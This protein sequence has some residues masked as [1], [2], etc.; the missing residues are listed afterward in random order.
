MRYSTPTSI[1]QFFRYLLFFWGIVTIAGCASSDEKDHSEGWSAQQL[2]NEA[3][4]ERI[5]GNYETALEYYQKLESRYPFGRYAQQAQIETI[6]VYYKSDEPAQAIASAERFIKLYPRHDHIDYV[7]YLKGITNF[8]LGKGFFD[9]YLPLDPAQRDP[10]SA[11][12]AFQDFGELIKHFPNSKYAEDARQRM[13]YLRNN[14]AKHEVYVADYYLRRGAYVAA[15][16]R[17]K[18]VV[19]NYQGA[20]SIA[21]ALLVMI[22]AYKLMGLD[23]LS[24]EALRVLQLNFPEH[25]EVAVVKKMGA[26]K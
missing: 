15:A 18:Y 5:A 24:L 6:Y 10:G 22:E 11:L 14:L 23:Q 19:E 16:N 7:Y 26:D 13:L 1:I 21:D 17:G 9:R 2:Y 8:N 3:K 25:P 20:P 12:K 4:S